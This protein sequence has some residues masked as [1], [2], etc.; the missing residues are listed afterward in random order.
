M[1]LELSKAEMLARWMSRRYLEPVRADCLVERTDAVDLA[2]L[3]AREARDW[4]LELLATAPAELLSPVD[5]AKDCEAEAAAD[6]YSVDVWMPENVVRP[7]SVRLAGWYRAATVVDPD[8]PAA[9]R[10]AS[11]FGAGGEAAPLLAADV[12]ARPGGRE[13][14]G[15][16]RHRRGALPLRRARPLPD[17]RKTVNEVKGED[18]CLRKRKKK[19]YLNLSPFTIH[20]QPIKLE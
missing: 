10:C 8:S 4:Y 7:L 2:A 15:G 13:P 11:R 3:C 20:L 14:Y 1:K 18:K 19:Y 12:A 5:V 6:G 17:Q 9:R 16:G